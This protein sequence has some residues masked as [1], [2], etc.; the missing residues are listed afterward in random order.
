MGRS[1]VFAELSHNSTGLPIGLR[2][3]GIEVSGSSGPRQN[4]RHLK[5][6]AACGE[7]RRFWLD[8]IDRVSYT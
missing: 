8:Q 4:G 1:L 5:G 2:G 3:G 6:A 7:S